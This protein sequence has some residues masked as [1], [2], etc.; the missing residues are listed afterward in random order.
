MDDDTLDRL[1]LVAEVNE[2][3]IAAEVR[4][5][6]RRYLESELEAEDFPRRLDEAHARQRAVM[7]RIVSSIGRQDP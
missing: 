5:A 3:N 4:E 7:R 2:T 1:R 6:V